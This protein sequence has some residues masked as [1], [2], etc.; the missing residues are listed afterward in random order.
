MKEKQRKF[1]RDNCSVF[2]D[3]ASW[4]E[5]ISITK[6]NFNKGKKMQVWK[7]LILFN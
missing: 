3:M 1:T 7:N 4:L 5:N 2:P 6:L